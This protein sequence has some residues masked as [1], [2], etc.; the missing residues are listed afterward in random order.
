MSTLITSLSWRALC[1]RS[2]LMLVLTCSSVGRGRFYTHGTVGS[3]VL[4]KRPASEVGGSEGGGD[5]GGG[6]G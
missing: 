4:I 6:V 5:G 3:D 2:G 1:N